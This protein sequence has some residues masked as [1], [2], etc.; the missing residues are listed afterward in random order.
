MMGRWRQWSFAQRVIACAL[1][2]AGATQ[3]R[4]QRAQPPQ[5]PPARPPQ[6]AP[7]PQQPLE[8]PVIQINPL[9]SKQEMIRDR[10]QRFQDRVFSLREQL[11][12]TEPENAA[13]LDQALQRATTFAVLASRN[14]YDLVPDAALR[15]TRLRFALLDWL[16]ARPRA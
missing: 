9:A 5:R 16:K 2:V 10:F 1:I 12:D 8:E 3:V 11:S 14:T 6:A 13:R 7:Q 15:Q 4:G